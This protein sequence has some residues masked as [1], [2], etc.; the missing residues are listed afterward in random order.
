[1]RVRKVH[2]TCR[3]LYLMGRR[4][5]GTVFFFLDSQ[6]PD[7][8]DYAPPGLVYDEVPEEY[9]DTF[10]T[11]EQRTVGPIRDRWGILMTSLVPVY[12]QNSGKMIAVLGMDID[13]G[14]W[15]EQVVSRCLI[16]V[17]LT[18]S[19]LLLTGLLLIMNKNRRIVESQYEAKKQIV[20]ELQQ[21]L[22]HV[23][24][25]QGLLPI[26]A[27]CKKVR[28][29]KGYWNQIDTYLEKHSEVQFSH[30]LCEECSEK[31]YGGEAWYN[32]QKKE[33]DSFLEP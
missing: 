17:S 14:D 9:L 6:P 16:P 13:A 29:S 28:D 1:M 11:G 18:L 3:F 21:A 7:S 2:R 32:K 8:K 31:I 33:K 15:K 5:D 27:S 25:L 24:K 23:K 30:G 26:C 4:G 22:E 10:D 12:T 20:L 19:I